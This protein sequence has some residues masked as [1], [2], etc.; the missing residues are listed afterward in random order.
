MGPLVLTHCVERLGL[1]TLASRCSDFN[2][3]AA[4]RACGMLLP[5]LARR[6]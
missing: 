4:Y 6:A 3:L 1:V 2:D 5:F